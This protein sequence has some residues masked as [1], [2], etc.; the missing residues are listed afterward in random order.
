MTPRNLLVFASLLLVNCQPSPSDPMVDTRLEQ[1]CT[2]WCEA[3]VPC[4][5]YYAE[6]QQFDDLE[7]C[8][9]SCRLYAE[10]VQEQNGESCYDIVLDDRECASA[11]TCE[12][13]VAYEEFSFAE[14]PSIT[15]PPCGDEVQALINGCDV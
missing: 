12:E 10:M 4:S 1:A 2:D 3:A 13:F 14:P 11:L 8:E 6:Q 7:S 9:A 5:T 15:P